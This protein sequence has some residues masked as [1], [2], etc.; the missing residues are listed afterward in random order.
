MSRAKSFLAILFLAAVGTLL[1]LPRGE[2][3]II[4]DTVAESVTVRGYTDGG[5]PL[6][7]VHAEEGRFDAT[8][9]ILDRVTVEFHGEDRTTM[10]VQ[11]D[12]LERTDEISRLSGNVRIERSDDLHLNV[13]SLTWN[14]SAERLESGPMELSTETLRVSAAEFGYDLSAETASFSGDVEAEVDFETDWV[15]QADHAEESKGIVE[16]RGGVI[17]ESAENESFRCESLQIKTD[18][19]IAC[20]SGDVVGQWPSGELSAES[21][22]LDKSGVQAK[23]HVVARLDLE[24]LRTSDDT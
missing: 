11:G 16:F 10:N 18:Q 14:E 20:L 3:P 22:C 17:A 15:I 23:G 9:Q 21:V 1:F 19:E 2:N 13:D 4:E 7:T 8:H 24:E 12:R 6:W 5:E